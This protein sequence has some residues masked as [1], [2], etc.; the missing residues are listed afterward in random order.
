MKGE[1]M[2]IRYWLS[3]LAM[4]WSLLAGLAA[5]WLS[6]LFRASP[7]S[8]APPSTDPRSLRLVPAARTRSEI[9][10]E[11]WIGRWQDRLRCSAQTLHPADTTGTETPA[12]N[13]AHAIRVRA[14]SG[15]GRS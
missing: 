10:F 15:G 4:A 5:I 2:L 3:A 13:A 14:G 1:A 9:E 11:R 6:G 8:P 7:P 12:A